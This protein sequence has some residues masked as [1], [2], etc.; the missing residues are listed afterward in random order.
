MTHPAS[1]DISTFLPLRS[2]TSWAFK[3]VTDKKRTAIIAALNKK[4][5]L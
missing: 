2:D 5:F 4:R 3:V 1:P